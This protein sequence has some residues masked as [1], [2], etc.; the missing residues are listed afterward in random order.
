MMEVWATLRKRN[1]YACCECRR[2][3]HLTRHLS[4]V[5]V[6]IERNKKHQGQHGVKPHSL[7]L[8]SWHILYNTRVGRNLVGVSFCVSCAHYKF[9]C[10]WIVCILPPKVSRNELREL[11]G[12]NT[13]IHKC[14][15]IFHLEYIC[16]S[17]RIHK[18]IADECDLHDNM[19]ASVFPIFQNELSFAP[20]T[21]FPRPCN[22]FARLTT[23]DY[24]RPNDV[25][26]MRDKYDCPR[27]V[28]A[29][30]S[31]QTDIY[32]TPKRYLFKHVYFININVLWSV[33]HTGNV[34]SLLEPCWLWRGGGHKC[35]WHQLNFPISRTRYTLISVSRTFV[36]PPPKT[37]L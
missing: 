1:V 7:A 22:V 31:G 34:R 13:G 25:L 33:V 6:L 20:H 30:S 21:F 19:R 2:T 12:N 4:H 5:C 17:L 29:L 24:S 32:T 16:S 3:L 26:C 14:T 37:I 23:Y 28:I 8:K 18:N 9:F 10:N 15:Y 27:A 11:W 35:L 36:P